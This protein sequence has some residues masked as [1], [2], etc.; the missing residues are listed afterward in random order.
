MAK[1]ACFMEDCEYRSKRP[2]RKYK[3]GDGSRLYGCLLPAVTIAEIFDPDN[4]VVAVVGRDNMA[5][6]SQY[7][8]REAENS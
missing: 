6:C 1:V 7:T 3:G 5:A 2:M 4:Y 8:P